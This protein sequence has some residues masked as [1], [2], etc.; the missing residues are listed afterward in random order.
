MNLNRREFAYARHRSTLE[1]EAIPP[2]FPPFIV[3]L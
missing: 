1:S 3:K 2:L